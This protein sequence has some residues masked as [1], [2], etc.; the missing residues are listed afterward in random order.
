MFS[1]EINHFPWEGTADSPNSNIDF[2][3]AFT[4]QWKFFFIDENEFFSLNNHIKVFFLS[5]PPRFFLYDIIH[6]STR[7]SQLRWKTHLSMKWKHTLRMTN[8]KAYILICSFVS[9]PS[10][11]F[12]FEW[13]WERTEIRSH[14][15]PFYRFFLVCTLL[16]NKIY[17]SINDHKKSC[18]C[19]RT[20]KKVN[21]VWWFLI[22]KANK[23][24]RWWCR[25]IVSFNV[26][27]MLDA[28]SKYLKNHFCLPFSI[29]AIGMFTWPL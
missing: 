25:W 8:I 6:F 21:C 12:I 28:Y 5:F 18:F 19:V 15:I 9:F 17:I 11:L 2:I 4:N 3:S 27:A 24:N 29:F 14:Y 22:E 26:P 10:Y 13:S 23:A 20:Q 1:T 7:A 16:G